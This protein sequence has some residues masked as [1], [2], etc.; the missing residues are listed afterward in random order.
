VYSTRIHQ[1]QE[2]ARIE[3]LVERYAE[4]LAALVPGFEWPAREL[5]RIWRLLV[6]NG[7][8]DSVCGCS[9]DEVA[10]AVDARHAEARSETEEIVEAAM[11]SLAAQVG[12]AGTLRFN[13]S[14][15]ER[16]GVPGLGWRV[17]AI[18]AEPREVPVELELALEDEPD[19]GDLYNFCPGADSACLAPAWHVPGTQGGATD[20]RIHSA[21]REGEPFVRLDVEIDNRRPD[22]RLRL[23]I[24][25]PERAPGAVAG[26]P[27]ELVT[28]GLLSEG[29]DFEASSPTWPAR[30]VVLAGGVAVLAEGVIE[31]EIVSGR[32]L[33]VTLLR[34][35]GTIS[36]ATLA[37]R[38]APAGPDVPTPDAQMI[39]TTSLALA[40]FPHARP[41]DLLPA[42]EC[43]ALPIRSAPAPGGGQ[44]PASGTLLHV[45]GAALSSVRRRGDSV[46]VRIWNPSQE[47]VEAEVG[48][49]AVRLGPARIETISLSQVPGTWLAPA[50][51]R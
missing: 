18:P 51:H 16:D 41:E 5:D 8:H 24:P 14:P 47:T 48:G 15:F 49:E 28:R 33:A 46:A 43:F 40:V 3:A 25:L 44:L 32:E 13:P 34:C 1:K 20:V 31:Y 11:A 7:A 19:V 42:W 50:W 22:H 27:F 23:R 4:P 10:R 29:G 38:P 36:R 2:R 9:V 6:L 39:G 17:D 45:R 12:A 37:T 35:V 26:S 30:G 21:Q